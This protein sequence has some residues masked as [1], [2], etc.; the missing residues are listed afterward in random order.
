M[1]WLSIT[2]KYRVYHRHGMS[3]CHECADR[4]KQ[5]L[6]SNIFDALLRQF[7]VLINAQVMDIEV[8]TDE[9]YNGAHGIRIFY[10]GKKYYLD[11]YEVTE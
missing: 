9:F 2:F 10:M 11:V 3:K 1:P 7:E 5:A 6:L 8:D 4:I